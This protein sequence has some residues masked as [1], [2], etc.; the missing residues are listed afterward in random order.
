MK[1]IKLNI[2]DQVLNKIKDY[3]IINSI[4]DGANTIIE[5]FAKIIV[6]AIQ[7]EKSEIGIEPK[8][9]KKSDDN[10]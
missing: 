5:E 2:D 9:S 1:T 6:K 3:L 10:D 7:D 8:K 4:C